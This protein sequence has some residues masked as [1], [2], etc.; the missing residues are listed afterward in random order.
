MFDGKTNSIKQLWRNLNTVYFKTDVDTSLIA[1]PQ[2]SA[3]LATDDQHY[4]W[5]HCF[6]LCCTT[7]TKTVKPNFSVMST[8]DKF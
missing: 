4:S 3:L 6:V 7:G 5:Q 2:L 8:A 1:V